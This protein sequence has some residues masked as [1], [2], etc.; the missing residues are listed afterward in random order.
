MGYWI[1]M[2][3]I[4]LLV[5]GIL[6]AIGSVSRNKAPKDINP[7]YGY[8]T[9]MSMKNK[10]TWEFANKYFGRLAWKWGT[11]MLIASF[12]PMLALFFASEE[13]VSI[14]GS[15]LVTLQLIPLLGTIP[16]VERALK[17]EFDKDGI[18]RSADKKG[19]A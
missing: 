1:F 5:P 3:C 2:T 10:D 13:V 7:I 16:I 9:A 14:V 12:L 11:I 19:T 18:R 17:K 6:I 8:R 15:V 4:C